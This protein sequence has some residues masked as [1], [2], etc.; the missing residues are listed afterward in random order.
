MQANNFQRLLNVAARAVVSNCNKIVSRSHFKPVFT[1]E[2]KYYGKFDYHDQQKYPR[3]ISSIKEEELLDE[4][5]AIKAQVI[6]KPA[7]FHIVKRI[8]GNGSTIKGWQVWVCLRRLNLHSD[9][10]GDVAVVPNTPQYNALISTVKHLVRVIPVKLP[11]DRFPTEEDIGAIKVCPYTGK[12]EK[13]ERLRFL[14]KRQYE[15]PYLWKGNHLQYKLRR[16]VGIH[17]NH[18]LR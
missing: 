15:K 12:V 1:Y 16:L 5:H 11:D 2:D 18:H 10:P 6:D 3:R 17:H 8:R 14:A 4:I 13:D 7:P 9:E